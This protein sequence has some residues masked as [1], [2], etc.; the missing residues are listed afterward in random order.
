MTAYKVL[1]IAV[2]TGKIGYALLEG[3][4]LADWGLS[5][6]ASR[7][8]KRAAAKVRG[9]IELL[10]PEAVVTER[11]IKKS[12]KRGKT[13]ALLAAIAKT[14]RKASAVHATVPRVRL[15]K[16]KYE[17]AAMLVKRYP[18]LRSRLPEKPPIW[19][20]EPPNMIIFEALTLALSVRL[21]YE[22]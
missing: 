7:S 2:A 6:E 12:R 1:G 5:R 16:N 11:L 8:P 15:H 22:R 13:I 20:P 3:E 19:L 18:E 14:A 10:K 9:W 4:R 21:S 17:E